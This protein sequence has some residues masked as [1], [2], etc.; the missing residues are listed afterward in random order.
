MIC[1]KKEILKSFL[2]SDFV[3]LCS[4]HSYRTWELHLF[5]MILVLFSYVVLFFSPTLWCP[6]AFGSGTVDVRLGDVA[7]VL[8]ERQRILGLD[9]SL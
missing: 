7:F 4:V 1:V 9:L 5:Y 8:R 6:S 3:K 2:N